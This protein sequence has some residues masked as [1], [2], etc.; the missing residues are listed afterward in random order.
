M[1]LMRE[2]WENDRDTSRAHYNKLMLAITPITLN[3]LLF[4]TLRST[5]KGWHF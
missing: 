4:N 1:C 2:L 5:K 3:L